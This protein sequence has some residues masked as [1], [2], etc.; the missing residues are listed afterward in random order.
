MNIFLTHHFDGVS[1]KKLACRE[2][3]ALQH[4]HWLDALRIVHLY[5]S[6]HREEVEGE[7]PAFRILVKFLECIITMDV[8]E[9][10]DGFAK[11]A[12]IRWCAEVIQKSRLSTSDIAFYWYSEA[13]LKRRHYLT[14][15]IH[16]FLWV[17]GQN[18]LK[19]KQLLRFTIYTRE[20]VEYNIKSILL[21]RN[22]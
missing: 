21:Y 8:G 17:H 3:R 18:V 10:F 20:E 19:D 1:D 12:N 14:D 22:L 2:E 7:A 6:Q 4:L 15:F 5:A 11:T 13:G 9:S 16:H